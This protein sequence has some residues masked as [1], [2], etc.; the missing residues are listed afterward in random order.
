MGINQFNEGED[1]VM[2]DFHIIYN[3][4]LFYQCQKFFF[5]VILI[6]FLYLKKRCQ[7][8]LQNV[9]DNKTEFSN[10][11]FYLGEK[12]TQQENNFFTTENEYPIEDQLLNKALRI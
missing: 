1:G 10:C 12:I 11:R 6:L 7:N 8:F 4:L 3:K 9:E 2:K 5:L